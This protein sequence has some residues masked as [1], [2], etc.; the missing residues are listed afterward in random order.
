MPGQ[1]WDVRQNASHAR[2][3]GYQA[4]DAAAQ[5][6]PP[7]DAIV[8][9]AS[10]PAYNLDHAITLARAARCRLVLLCS[11][12]THESEV[13]SILMA[14]SFSDATVI[15][16]P[17]SYEHHFFKFETTAWIKEKFPGRDSDLS[18][19]RNVGLVLARM[20]GWQ[21]I[22]F[23]DD[24]I[25]DLDVTALS[26]T[27][28]LVGGDSPAQRFCAAGMSA[29]RFPDNSVVCHARREIGK[30]QDIFVSGSALALNCAVSIAF[31]PDIYNE[32]W[33]FFYRY[34][35]DGRLASS[36]Y[37]ATQLAYDP[38]ANPGRAANEE[39]GDVIAEG[40][41]ALLDQGK[42]AEYAVAPRYWRRFLGAR[43]EI[44]DQVIE[45]SEKAPDGIQGKMKLAVETARECLEK[46]QPDMCVEYVERWRWDLG[47]WGTTLKEIPGVAS[48][49]EAL[50]ILGLAP[51]AVAD[52]MP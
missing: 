31:F 11:R 40:L 50:G 49:S 33:L 30:F 3:L 36:G 41:Y 52:A 7:L 46:I 14:R 44:L 16:I 39:F 29:I 19:K 42:S 37:T 27:I 8:V 47:Q 13:R 17:R 48:A 24:D 22:F 2:L 4:P 5:H 45:K 10:R 43:K 6:R 38:F 28:S 9:P 12:D 20:L 23:M 15:E 34:A 21:R 35:A 25:R 1:D 26:A 32:D 51:A 18:M